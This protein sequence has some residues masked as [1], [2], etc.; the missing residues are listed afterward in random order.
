MKFKFLSD[1]GLSHRQ[2]ARQTG[3]SKRT[4]TRIS[5]EMPIRVVDDRAE[6]ERRRVGRPSTA[7][8]YEDQIRQILDE[9]RDLRSVEIL[10]RLRRGAPTDDRPWAGSG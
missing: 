8:Q 2:V 10:H 7:A 9:K 1:P 5:P 6:I 4:V 3:V